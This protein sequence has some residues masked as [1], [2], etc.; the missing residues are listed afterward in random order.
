LPIGGSRAQSEFALDIKQTR[1]ISCCQENLL[2]ASGSHFGMAVDLWLVMAGTSPAMTVTGQNENC[3][4][5][6][7]RRLRPN[8]KKA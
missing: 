3:W 2:C 1:G 4:L 7:T 8:L 6:A 5:G